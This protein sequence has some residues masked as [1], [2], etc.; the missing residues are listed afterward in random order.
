[1]L[2]L[3]VGL[4]PPNLAAAAHPPPT[5]LRVWHILEELVNMNAAAPPAN[6]FAV[7]FDA[8]T[9]MPPLERALQVGAGARGRGRGRTTVERERR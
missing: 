9:E 5:G 8:L 6:P 3:C 1:V 2:S 7:N 4:D